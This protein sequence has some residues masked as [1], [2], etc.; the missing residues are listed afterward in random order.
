MRFDPAVLEGIGGGT[1]NLGVFRV[2]GDQQDPES[3]RLPQVEQAG[4]KAVADRRI[5]GGEWLVEQ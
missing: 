5:K 3:E 1:E 2:V 4:P